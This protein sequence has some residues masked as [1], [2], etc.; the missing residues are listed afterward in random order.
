MKHSDV[1]GSIS[2]RRFL[3]ATAA[4]GAGACI[5]STLCAPFIRTARGEPLPGGTLDPTTLPK[6]TTDLFI[7]PL[8]PQ[9]P[10]ER[11]GVFGTAQ[12]ANCYAVAARQFAQQILP[13][14]FPKTTVWG[15]GS[16]FEPRSFRYPSWTIEALQGRP[17]RITWINGL[18]DASKRYLRPLLP[19]DQTLHWANPPGGSL[20]RDMHGRSQDPYAGPVPLV[21]HLH[22][23]HSTDESDGYPEA[24]FLPNAVDIPRDYAR[25]GSWYDTFREQFHQERNGSWLP[26]SATFE[27][28]N[29]QAAT[30]L[31]FHDHVLGMTRINIYSGLAGFYLLRGGPYDL[32]GD[33]LPHD[34]HECTLM[35]QDRSFNA[36]GSLFYP[37][38]RFFFDQTPPPYSPY[39]DVPP[40]WNSEF[41]ANTIVVNGNTWPKLAV[42]PR[43]YRLRILNACS[44][45]FL[46]LRLVV[47]TPT[48]TTPDL[49]FWQIGTDGGFLQEP[50]ARSE[51]L[52]APAERIDCIVDFSGFAG[53][54]LFLLNVGPDEPFG[55]GKPGTDFNIADQNTT[56][57][58]MRFDVDKPLAGSDTSLMPS[59]LTLPQPPAPLTADRVRQLALNE[60]EDN[61]EPFGP[62]AV[63]LGVMSGEQPVPKRWDDPITENP[64]AGTT[65]LWDIHNFT[66]D[67]H[68]IHLHQVQFRI[69][70]RER[71]GSSA[72]RTAEPWEIGPK[73]TVIAYPG[74]ITRI[75]ATFDLSGLYVWHCHILEHED[76]EMMRPLLVGDPLA[77]I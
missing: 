56:G 69:I 8:M 10:G 20:E 28:D 15:Y 51:L 19:V 67:A 65:E 27:Y 62:I 75:R 61:K 21:T 70:N 49:Q 4:A 3:S 68:P 77:Q 74:E 34:D 50:V 53:R 12:G 32:D 35:I 59:S 25:V 42:E 57:Q 58:V 63:L 41:F 33:T 24:W 44:S 14:G 45:R 16:I 39:S 40:I 76:N 36:D 13:K 55:G 47:G 18:I 1:G 52:I 30:A 64:Q 72:L 46:I 6:Y 31:W 22:G 48:Q 2:R 26:G 73:D 60:L 71:V 43:R 38:S 23:G 66:D 7:P 5:G 29:T 11:R 17:S 54:S 9:I 37:A